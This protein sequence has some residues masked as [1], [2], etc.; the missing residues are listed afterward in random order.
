MIL[1]FSFLS[2]QLVQFFMERPFLCVGQG[3]KLPEIMLD[4]LHTLI[5]AEDIG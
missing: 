5:K 2:E 3:I 4:V 1:E